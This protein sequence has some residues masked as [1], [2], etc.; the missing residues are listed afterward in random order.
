[1]L[2][3]STPPASRPF[4]H[5]PFPTY[6]T[7][8]LSNGTEV[9]L[10]PYGKVEVIEIQA[11]FR[12]GKNH[13]PVPGLLSHAAKMMQEGTERYNSL[14]FSRQL[15]T[16][17]AWMSHEVEEEATAFKLATTTPNI[18]YTLPLLKEML[19]HPTFPEQEFQN[20]KIR[21]IQGARIN[22]QKTT[23]MAARSFGHRIFGPKHPYGLSVGPDEI[24]TLQLE[25][26]KA[27]YKQWLVPGNMTLAVVGIFDEE[28]LLPVLEK[29]FGTLKRE[30]PPELPGEDFPYTP[31]NKLGRHHIPK[32][33]MQ[34][35]VRLGHLG[36]KRSHPEFY[37]IMVLNTILGGYFGSRLMKNIR[38]E[39]GYTYGIYS[40]YVAMKHEGVFLVQG[41]V[42]NEYV[43]E[44]ILEVKKEIKLLQDEKIEEGELSLVKNYLLGKSISERETPFQMGDW[45]RF[46]LVNDIS[47]KDLDKRFEVVRGI[48]AE[49]V[50]ELARKF[51]RPDEMLEVVAG[52]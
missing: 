19:L 48:K 9:I 12:V 36:V 24:E 49:E 27:A 51:L 28:D 34:S 22:A 50:P 26:L 3:R 15:D 43:E 8:R 33:G 32:E 14:E 39:K 10:L 21:A 45:L 42:G 13:L 35:T 38:E 44:T 4:H 11:I 47:F 23:K 17:G 46:S 52:G 16:F 18:A 31:L 7:H 37:K 30:N 1:M 25:D 6:S 2:D 20:M 5:I 40:G 41:D 29:E